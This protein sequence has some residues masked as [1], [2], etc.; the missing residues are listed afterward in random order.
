MANYLI[1]N[2][3]IS[4]HNDIISYSRTCEQD[5]LIITQNGLVHALVTKTRNKQGQKIGMYKH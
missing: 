4:L 1:W 2:I 5:S 3:I